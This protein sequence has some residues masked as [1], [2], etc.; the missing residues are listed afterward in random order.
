MRG[1]GALKARPVTINGVR[2][3]YAGAHDAE[4]RGYCFQH[5]DD[6][7]AQRSDLTARGDTQSKGFRST[8]NFESGMM[9]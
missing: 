4:E 2:D 1:E 5:S 7:I 8:P 9:F 3:E 6:P